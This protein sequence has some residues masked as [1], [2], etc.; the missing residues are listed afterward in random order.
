MPEKYPFEPI[1]SPMLD[2]LNSFNM[3]ASMKSFGDPDLSS[4]EFEELQKKVN[5]TRRPYRLSD[6]KPKTFCMGEEGWD[7]DWGRER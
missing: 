3:L 5:K 2:E 7:W 4:E 6:W 1:T